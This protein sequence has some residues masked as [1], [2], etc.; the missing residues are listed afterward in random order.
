M[1]A[2][3]ANI[4]KAGAAIESA[5]LWPTWL[6]AGCHRLQGCVSSTLSQTSSVGMIDVHKPHVSRSILVHLSPWLANKWQVM[7]IPACSSQTHAV[8]NCAHS[9]ISHCYGYGRALQI[10]DTSPE[11]PLARWLHRL[12]FQC[13]RPTVIPNTSLRLHLSILRDVAN[14]GWIVSLPFNPAPS[15]RSSKTLAI[16]QLKR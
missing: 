5:A 15:M 4:V 7:I 13:R 1:S 6:E 12:V 9:N 11:L 3:D 2:E 14:K 10:H 16:L 8:I